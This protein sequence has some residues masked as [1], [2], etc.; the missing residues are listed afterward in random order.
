MFANNNANV[1]TENHYLSSH[2]IGISYHVSLGWN[3]S[4]EH[5]TVITFDMFLDWLKKKMDIMIAQCALY[6]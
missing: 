1:S 4:K 5:L 2:F 6:G 3:K